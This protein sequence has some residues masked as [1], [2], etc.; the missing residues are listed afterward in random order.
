MPEYK[1]NNVPSLLNIPE[2][3]YIEEWSTFAGKTLS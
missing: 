3:D 2:I 1:N